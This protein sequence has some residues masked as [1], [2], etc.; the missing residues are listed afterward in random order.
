M[1]KLFFFFFFRKFRWNFFIRHFRNFKAII[2]SIL[3]DVRNDW[4]TID[5]F[6]SC[7]FWDCRFGLRMLKAIAGHSYLR[8]NLKSGRV[9]TP[10]HS[11]STPL[12]PV[13]TTVAF[14]IPRGGLS[15]AVWKWSQGLMEAA[16]SF[17][18]RAT[19]KCS[20][21]KNHEENENEMLA[22]PGSRRKRRQREGKK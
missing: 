2:L 10:Q 8:I 19:Q 1:A 21:R 17:M 3:A 12:H 4:W 14:E 13:G 9:S 7:Y 20:R 6:V 15:T 11:E 18:V 5:I 22:F 16:R